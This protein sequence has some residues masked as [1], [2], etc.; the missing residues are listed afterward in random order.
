MTYELSIFNF[1]V[2]IFNFY[3]SFNY[4]CSIFCFKSFIKII[5]FLPKLVKKR[6]E[7]I[8]KIFGILYCQLISIAQVY[9]N[10]LKDTIYLEA[11]ESK[12][13]ERRK[14]RSFISRLFE[15]IDAFLITRY[16]V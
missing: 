14:S 13:F 11:N 12:T 8:F 2:L 16:Q 5:Y 7:K 1:Y 4:Q 9:L 15:I 3:L 6:E 10:Y